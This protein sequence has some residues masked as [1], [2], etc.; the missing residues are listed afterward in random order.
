MGNSNSIR[1]GVSGIEEDKD[2]S[3]GTAIPL[4]LPTVESV[5]TERRKAKAL[6]LLDAKMVELSKTQIIPT[7]NTSTNTTPN[8][9][10]D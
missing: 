5:A 4:P 7:T 9:G 3:T 1:T 6:K 8:S 10:M 2:T